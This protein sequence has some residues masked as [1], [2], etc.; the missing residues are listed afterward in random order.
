[1]EHEKQS[2]IADAFGAILEFGFELF[3][4]VIGSLFDGF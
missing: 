2:K 3:C 1:M 4:Q